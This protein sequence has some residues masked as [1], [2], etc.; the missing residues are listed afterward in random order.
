M[1]LSKVE[2]RTL[3]TITSGIEV[4]AYDTSTIYEQLIERKL[5]VGR[6]G[7]GYE[8]T[9]NGELVVNY[10]LDRVIPLTPTFIPMFDSKLSSNIFQTACNITEHYKGLMREQGVDV[11]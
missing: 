6:E 7:G 10:I 5:I 4:K 3:L 8:L 11:Q 9:E 1:Q 2:I